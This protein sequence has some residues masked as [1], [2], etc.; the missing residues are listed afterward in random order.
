MYVYH[1]EYHKILMMHS[2]GYSG[3]ALE[4]YQQ[5]LHKTLELACEPFSGNFTADCEQ[6]IIFLSLF[7]I[8]MLHEAIR[9]FRDPSGFRNSEQRMIEK[10]QNGLAFITKR[11]FSRSPLLRHLRSTKK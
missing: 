2:D 5:I 9:R 11:N 4:K 3:I 10:N 6:F 7:I 8:G 1:C